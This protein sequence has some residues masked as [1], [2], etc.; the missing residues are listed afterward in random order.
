MKIQIDKGLLAFLFSV[1][2]KYL[3]YY[4]GAF[5]GLGI[6]HYIQ[7]ELP[8][9]A[10]E[11]AQMA[12]GKE[13]SFSYSILIWFAA[14][15]ILFRTASRLLFFYPA[16]MMQRDVRVEIIH[17]LEN[18]LPLRYLEKFD[19]GQVF[20]IVGADIDAIRGLVGFGLLQI[21]NIIIALSV[22]VP[23]LASFEPRLLIALT[24]LFVGFV[25]FT[26]IVAQNR[27]YYRL[28][29]DY[30]GKINQ[31]IIES[32]QGKETIQNYQSESIFFDLFQK[33]SYRELLN[34]YQA[35][36]GI[37]FSLPLVPL[38]LGISLLWG[39][40]IV[41]NL[42]L[43]T[44]ALVLFSGFIFLFLEPLMFLSWIGVVFARSFVSWK[45]FKELLNLMDTPHE[46]EEFVLTQAG[47]E[48]FQVL[49]WEKPRDMQITEKGFSALV[50]ATGVG[51]SY[52]LKQLALIY[53]QKNRKVSYVAQSPYLYNDTVESNIFLGM[54]QKDRNIELAKKLLKLF[55]L[56]V[57][58]SDMD[59]LLKLEVGEN[60][61][62][63]SG[64]QAKRICLIRSLLSG[65]D[66]LFWDD[67]FSSVDLLLERKIMDELNALGLIKDLTLVI[68]THRLSTLRFCDEYFLL[69]KTLGISE[70]G[71]VNQALIQKESKAYEHFKDQLAE[72]LFV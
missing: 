71:I 30:Q 67:P 66:T 6:L 72:N 50:G 12:D 17:R 64:G 43:G 15:I 41:H 49:F 42:V 61:K 59:D 40:I 29:Q 34:F 1:F 8:F 68:T 45:R 58:S 24:P 3:P 57:L 51:K 11:L 28:T 13:L 26:L 48:E 20:Q 16:R 25:F 53:R 33:T 22:L 10:R 55:E 23:K 5:I 63:V 62:R 27:K 44:S 31:F 14:G 60:G 7:S 4:L 36:K 35:G 38:G 37:A 54:E 21:G 47:K 9:L 46:M 32:Y 39:A 65:A 18:T 70:R 2:L 56:E 52:L 69:D 19:S